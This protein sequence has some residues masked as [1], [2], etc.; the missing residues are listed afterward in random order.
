[1]KTCPNVR[2]STSH[3]AFLH[4]TIGEVQ[5]AL[6]SL[7]TSISNA[8]FQNEHQILLLKHEI[9]NSCDCLGIV[10]DDFFKF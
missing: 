10:K 3:S 9:I 1:M 5:K 4:F 8:M 6:K 7:N 2:T